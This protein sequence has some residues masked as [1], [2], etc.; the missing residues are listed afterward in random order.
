MVAAGGA[1]VAKAPRLV[2]VDSDVQTD[3]PRHVEAEIAEH[4]PCGAGADH[5]DPGTVLQ[6]HRVPLLPGYGAS[7]EEFQSFVHLFSARRRRAE[8]LLLFL[9]PRQPVRQIPDA[10]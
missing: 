5:R 7:P 10:V 6:G 4:R 8:H 2:D 1:A 9:V 3:H